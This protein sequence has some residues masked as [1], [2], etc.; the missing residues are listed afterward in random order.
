MLIGFDASRAFGKQNTG[1][2]NY[3]LNLLR[4]ISRVDRTNEYVVYLRSVGGKLPKTIKLPQNF[5]YKIIRPSRLW[6]QAGLALETWKSPVDLVFIP[7]HTLPI[8]RKRKMGI[9]NFPKY[10]VTMHDLGVEYLPG[11]HKFP[12]RY[13][14]DLASRYA[15]KHADALIAVSAA[16][17]RDLVKKYRVDP[18]SVFVVHEGVD[19]GF[20]K[21]Q[22]RSNIEEL[23]KRYKIPGDYFLF[24]GT[25]QPRKNLE[26]LVDAFA[27]LV[28][29]Q[30]VK[31]IISNYNK[32]NLPFLVIAGKYGWDYGSILAAPK[33]LGVEEFVR[34]VGYVKSHD[35]P[36]LYSGAISYL[37]PSLFE[38]FNLPILEALSC[39]CRVVA[40]NIKVHAEILKKV[41][42]MKYKVSKEPKNSKKRFFNKFEPMVLVKASSA[43]DWIRFL[44][45]SITKNNKKSQRSYLGHNSFSWQKTAF[46]TLRVFERILR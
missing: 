10:V 39:G 16:T 13:Y 15:A 38:G 22:S 12:D 31:N 30:K 40:S 41:L 44:Y 25:V 46:E 23:K 19:K 21:R 20:F 4:A 33:R 2:E 18:K 32:P 14:L 11:Y 29:Y 24:V 37:T 34:F 43:E 6:T 17:K 36:T 45:Q 35:L 7:A 1:T 8:F 3:S 5:R 42:N 26:M 27:S 28:N 9:F